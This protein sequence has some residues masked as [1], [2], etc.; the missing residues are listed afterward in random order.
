[1]N[2]SLG[3]VLLFI[4]SL[5]IVAGVTEQR[6]KQEKTKV[7]YRYVKKPLYDMQFEKVNLI[8]SMPA[9]F[10]TENRNIF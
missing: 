6:M 2:N 3:L 10:S 1:M 8:K 4:G 5:M 7:V 9:L